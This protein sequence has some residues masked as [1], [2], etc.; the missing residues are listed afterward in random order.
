MTLL[1]EREKRAEITRTPVRHV[2]E[3]VLGVAGLVA[4]AVGAWIYYVPTDWFLGNLV[5]SWHLG[6]FTGAGFLLFAALGVLARKAYLVHRDWT[7]TSVWAAGFA[8]A[9]V[10]GAGVFALIWIL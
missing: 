1:L 7:A 6:M 4:A 10:V 2:T 3:W 9:A 8:V 5:E